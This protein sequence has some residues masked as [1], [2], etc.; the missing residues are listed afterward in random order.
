MQLEREQ[1]IWP[2]PDVGSNHAGA[3]GNGVLSSQK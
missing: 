1:I 2:A 3:A